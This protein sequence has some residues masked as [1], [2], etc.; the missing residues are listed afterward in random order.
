MHD[1]YH[2]KNMLNKLDIVFIQKP[3]LELQKHSSV[4]R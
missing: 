4:A 3:G 1:L 2:Y